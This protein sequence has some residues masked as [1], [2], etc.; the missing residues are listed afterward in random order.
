MNSSLWNFDGQ[1][2]VWRIILN[3][4]KWK[5]PKRLISLKIELEGSTSLY[6]ECPLGKTLTKKQL[7]I[8]FQD[9]NFTGYFIQDGGQTANVNFPDFFAS[10][11][12]YAALKDSL[13]GQGIRISHY[14]L[15]K[16]RLSLKSIPDSTTFEELLEL[17]SSKLPKRI[18]NKTHFWSFKLCSSENN[19]TK[20][21]SGFLGF[22]S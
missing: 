2:D 22:K 7:E 5:E 17:I 10:R 14:Q 1:E 19:F 21:L 3:S 16:Y 9:Y 12:V 6:L 11:D 4:D 8:I 13:F 20:R 18:G 15:K